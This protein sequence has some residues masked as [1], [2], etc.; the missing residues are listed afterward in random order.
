MKI[1]INNV[2]ATPMWAIPDAGVFLSYE[3]NE[4]VDVDVSDWTDQ[5][6]YT[7]WLS[8]RMGL[9]KASD[10]MSFMVDFQNQLNGVA[11][12]SAR[13]EV[14]AP[15]PVP[16]LTK[17]LKQPVLADKVGLDA[18]NK[19]NQLLELLSHNVATLK[20]LLPDLNYSELGSLIKLESDNKNRKT[21]LKLIREL[22]Q[23]KA[24]VVEVTKV[25]KLENAPLVS[26]V[27]ESENENIII[28]IDEGD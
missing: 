14:K 6:E 16:V 18:L 7:L 3:N 13:E 20:R 5:Q 1:K 24:P 11:V 8:L 28:H 10:A 12:Q 9:V 26:V 22:R 25:P 2:Q 4:W 23:A 21:I 17:E 19:A 15:L 27:E